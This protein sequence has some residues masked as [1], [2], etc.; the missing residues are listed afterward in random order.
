MNLP[1]LPYRLVPH[2]LSDEAAAYVSELL[3]DLAVAFDGQYFAQVRR[4]YDERQAMIERFCQD[5]QRRPVRLRRRR[6][7]NHP[8][9]VLPGVGCAGES[10]FTTTTV[11]I[12]IT[13]AP[14][15]PPERTA[16]AQGA[17]D[18]GSM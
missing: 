6:V 15:C 5:G 10:I 16:P 13:V 2:E 4:Y 12:A 8:H 17:D 7:L 1:N 9:P 18:D 3:N 11:I 14:P